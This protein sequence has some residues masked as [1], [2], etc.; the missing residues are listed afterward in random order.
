MSFS[1]NLQFLILF[2]SVALYTPYTLRNL[3]YLD[4]KLRRLREL[5]GFRQTIVA[6]QLAIEQSSYARLEQH[7]TH[8]ILDQLTRVAGLYSITIGELLD[9]DADTLIREAARRMTSQSIS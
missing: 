9:K 4:T 5:H 8:K 2:S 3:H 1:G 7:Q 6:D